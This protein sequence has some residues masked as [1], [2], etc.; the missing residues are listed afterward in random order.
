MDSRRISIKN[1]IQYWSNELIARIREANKVRLVTGAFRGKFYRAPEPAELAY[2]LI[3]YQ[4]NP[5]LNSLF[6]KLDNALKGEQENIIDINSML[7]FRAYTSHVSASTEELTQHSAKQ[8][9]L[10]N[11]TNTFGAISS[12]DSNLVIRAGE[13]YQIKVTVENKSN[14]IWQTSEET[15][16]FLSYHWYLENGSI[17]EW[18]GKRTLLAT[19]I[20][21]GE[22][23]ELELSLKTP[24]NLGNFLLELTMIME[25]KFWFEE[26]GFKVHRVAA[27][28]EFP[29]LFPHAYRI[30]KDMESM[31]EKYRLKEI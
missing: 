20:G 5:D 13:I 15:P 26:R 30:Y 17:F 3:Q 31:I 10:D 19:A 23:L 29:K 25:G 22:T 7:E 18:D 8:S 14:A 11:W 1:L 24:D 4:S 12:N 2:W 6:L 21:P 16:I 9:K 28:I 27:K